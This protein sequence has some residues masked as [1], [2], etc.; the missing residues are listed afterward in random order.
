[1]KFL[2]APDSY[3]NALSAL[4]VAKSLKAGLL[5]VYPGCRV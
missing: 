4:E 5:K 3:K 2:I 1:M